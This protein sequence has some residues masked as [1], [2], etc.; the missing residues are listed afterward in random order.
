V[1]HKK[2]ELIQ[3]TKDRDIHLILLQESWLDASTQIMDLPNF[4]VISRRDRSDRP[5]R[6]GVIGFVRHDVN[7]ISFLHKSENAERCWHV[8]QRDTTSIAICNWY[9]SPQASLDD[10]DSLQI[11]VADM[12]RQF[13]YFVISGEMNIHHKA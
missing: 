3:I 7:N 4:S 11:E 9:F 1:K 10:I 5:N 2:T 8:I 6:G 12:Q 13:D